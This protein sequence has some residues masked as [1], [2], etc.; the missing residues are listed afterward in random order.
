ML[1]VLKTTTFVKNRLADAPHILNSTETKR[2][3][4]KLCGASEYSTSDDVRIATYYDV[5][6]IYDEYPRGYGYIVTYEIGVGFYA[7]VAFDRVGESLMFSLE[8]VDSG[9]ALLESNEYF[10]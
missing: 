2:T 8:L 7:I 9:E 6:E 4:L 5:N 3:I 10:I 1:I